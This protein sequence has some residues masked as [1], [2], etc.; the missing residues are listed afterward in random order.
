MSFAVAR[1]AY[2]RCANYGFQAGVQKRY[3][4]RSP[5][6]AYLDLW[7]KHKVEYSK[8]MNRP[9]MLQS[10]QLV[11]Q[12]L[13]VE[14]TMKQKGYVPFLHAMPASSKVLLEFYKT[15]SPRVP[16]PFWK[17]FRSPFDPHFMGLKEL[18]K[19]IPSQDD[20]V[21]R[22]EFLSMSYALTSNTEGLES[23]ASWGFVNHFGRE[24]YFPMMNNLQSAMSD[25]EKRSGRKI[26]APFFDRARMLIRQYNR[27]SVGNFYCFG[28]PPAKVADWMYDSKPYY[29]PT[30][31]D[32]LDI[33]RHP[34]LRDRNSGTIATLILAKEVMTPSSGWV[35]VCANDSEADQFCKGRKLVPPGK[36]SLYREILAASPTEFEERERAQRLVLDENLK[37]LMSDLKEWVKTGKEIPSQDVSDHRACDMPEM[38]P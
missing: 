15:A 9:F 8:E 14:S 5:S 28:I 38:L 19:K 35:A 18:R 7:Q 6:Y 17:F 32:I 31:R 4:H 22:P 20:R 27:L 23:A 30:G 2:Q 3:T 12:I 24:Q 16:H 13:R 25:W 26:P 34:R 29:V 21:Q 36:V 1:G 11:S 37:A 10:P 33:V